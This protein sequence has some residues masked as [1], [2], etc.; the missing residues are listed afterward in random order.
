MAR[1]RAGRGGV[2]GS[3][4]VLLAMVAI[5]LGLGAALAPAPCWAGNGGEARSILR[6]ADRPYTVVAGEADASAVIQNPANLGYLQ[7]LNAVID[8]AVSSQLSGRRSSGVGAFMALP[9]PWDVLAIGVG[10]QAMWRTQDS[11]DPTAT[12][13]DSPYGKLSL[14]VSVPLMRWA[15]GLSVGLSYARLFSPN[16]LVA[17]GA[18][19]VDL[20]LSWR[21]NRYVSLAVVARHLN[22]P[23]LEGERYPVTLDPEL[24]LRPLGTPVLEFAA[25]VRTSFRGPDAQLFGYPAEPRVRVL[26]G[27]RGFRVFADAELMAYYDLAELS[28]REEAAVR[29]NLGVQFDTPHFGVAAG[30]SFAL[31][32]RGAEQPHGAVARIRVSRERYEEV[33]PTRPRRVTRL[34]LAGKRG[35]R[36]LAELVWII[37]DLARRRGGVILVEL[38]G[39]GFGLAQLEELR[40]ALLRFQ[41]AGGKVAVY[42]EGADLSDYFLAAIADRVI[43]HPERKLAIV[44]YSAHTFYWGELLAR[45]G[46]KAE[47]VRIAEYKGS[48][49]K[50]MR[51][52]PSA[53]VAAAN[54]ALVTDRW[55]HVVRLVARARARDPSVVSGWIDA[56]PWSA[57][58]ARR[59]GL[60]DELAWPDEL[61]ARLEAWLGRHLRIE[62]PPK[63]P[64]RPEGWRDPA[65]VAVLHINGDL[66]EGPSLHIPLLDRDVAGAETLTRQIEAL[67]DDS[68]VKAIVVRIDS[69]GGSV[70]ASQAIARELDLTRAQKPVVVSMGRVAASG[71][72]YVATGGDYIFTDATTITGSIGVF[73]PELDLSGLLE[74]FGVGI[75]QISIGDRATMVSSW[76]SQTPEDR[77]A[78]LAGVQQQYDRFIERVAAARAMTP[79][80]ADAVARGRLWSGVRAMEVGLVD[81]YGGMHEAVARAAKMAGLSEQL[82]VVHYPPKPTLVDQLR[83]LFGI[84][85]AL[86]LGRTGGATGAM[87][88]ASADPLTGRAL[89]FADP[90]LRVLGRVP[91]ALWLADGPE[92]MALA[93]GELEFED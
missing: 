62:A 93:E 30:P 15:P 14:A 8:I 4:A 67:R 49:E 82:A 36:E 12:A 23:R 31:G 41:G 46:V 81:R 59:R 74:K 40:E 10:V 3:L 56:A 22:A 7:G 71:G 28:D 55:N 48:P 89:R 24:A 53:P 13:I 2:S 6:D 84:N 91:A 5:V 34:S 39:T 51:S 43:A 75:D 77:A 26:V 44:G 76:R 64:V 20:A 85:L 90:L 68:D 80:E 21:A 9:L 52:G 29:V 50:L 88:M 27:G 65:H 42:L 61:D 78:I 19:T 73:Y 57:E 60:V 69:G 33:L 54:R 37:D 1:R 86:P 79:E 63:T 83:A 70:A 87:G 58:A 35:D 25:G 18:N 92:A 16:N 72:Y 45:L 11:G 47:F 38:A 32:T 66:V 17:R